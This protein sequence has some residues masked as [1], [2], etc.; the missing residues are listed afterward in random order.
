[1]KLLRR[2]EQVRGKLKI[3]LGYAAG[4]G[5]TYDALLEAAQQRLEEGVDVVAGYVET[6]GRVESDLLAHA[7][8]PGMRHTRRY[9]E[10]EELL[11]AGID[12]YTTLNIQHLESLKDIV[13]QI[14][15]IMVRDPVPDGWMKR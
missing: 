8:A 12:G 3:F 14:T 13:A 11:D 6:H 15:G 7:N 2:E 10:V 5:K 9:Q 4:G 1:M